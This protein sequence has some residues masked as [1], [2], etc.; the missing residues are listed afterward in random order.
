[1]LY[2]ASRA[3]LAEQVIRPAL[4]AGQCVIGDRYFSS[5][6]AYQGAGGV[7]AEDILT[8]GRIAVGATWPD[9]TILLD[10]PVEVGLERAKGKRGRKGRAPDRVEGKTVAYHQRVREIFLEQAADDPVHF[11]LVDGSPD[12]QQVH[13]RILEVLATRPWLRKRGQRQS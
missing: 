2:M 8:A 11:T 4:A 1:M 5:T 6:V 7:S 3:Q 13:R 10:L 12:A 9:V